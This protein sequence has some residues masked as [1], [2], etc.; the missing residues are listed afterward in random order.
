[1]KTIKEIYLTPTSPVTEMHYNKVWIG[2]GL[3][4]LLLAGGAMY[5]GSLTPY[6]EE[7]RRLLLLGGGL[8]L[9]IAAGCLLFLKGR[10]RR[11]IPTDGALRHDYFYFDHS[12]LPQFARAL[13]QEE[14]SALPDVA[15][16]PN[17]NARMEVLMTADHRFCVV[18]LWHYV[19]YAYQPV[20]PVY[21]IPY[22]RVEE[23]YCY[24]RAHRAMA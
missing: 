8:L 1:M 22:D 15:L 23:M 18:Q 10:E 14:L 9:A 2:G 3:L 16:L 6:E 24:L 12:L 20:S 4:M 7:A 19:P 11:Y 13:E 21:R 17:G 5:Q